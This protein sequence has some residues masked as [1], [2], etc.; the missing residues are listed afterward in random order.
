MLLLLLLLLL[1]LTLRVVVLLQLLPLPIRLLL[2]L[3][4]LLRLL[5]VL[6]EPA[7]LLVCMYSELSCDNIFITHSERLTL[8]WKL[9]RD[10]SS[11]I[12]SHMGHGM[13]PSS[14][15]LLK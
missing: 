15:L 2:L 9:V 5:L 6:P 1:K 12:L 8:P 4:L 14:R 3:L 11:L 10:H 7:R 13:L